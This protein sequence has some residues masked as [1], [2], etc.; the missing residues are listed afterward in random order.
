[1][2]K[3]NNHMQRDLIIKRPPQKSVSGLALPKAAHAT[4]IL[5]I[6]PGRSAECDFWDD[7][8][9]HKFYQSLLS[10]NPPKITVGEDSDLAPGGSAPFTT[11]G[12]T[13][14]VAESLNPEIDAEDAANDPAKVALTYGK[15]DQPVISTKRR[16]RP[17]KA[18]E[19]PEAE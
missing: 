4:S 13:L 6:K 14:E 5:V 11:F 18:A 17:A 19:A 15:D 2:A 9:N 12:E 3:I 1:M 7:I 8:K 16:G 10:S